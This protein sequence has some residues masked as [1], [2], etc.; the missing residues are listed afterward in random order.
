[1]AGG[2]HSSVPDIP[3][4]VVREIGRANEERRA[5][6]EPA[7][8]RGSLRGAGS[9]EKSRGSGRQNQRKVEEKAGAKIGGG[10]DESENRLQ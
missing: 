1:M 9:E 4:E 10:R 2:R 5:E 3:K 8:E 6:D 7:H